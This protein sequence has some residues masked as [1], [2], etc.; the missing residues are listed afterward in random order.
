MVHPQ[1]RPR[2]RAI[3][4]YPGSNGLAIYFPAYHDGMSWR[5]TDTGAIW[6]DHTTWDEFLADFTN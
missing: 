5:Y 4:S 3:A 1:N 6:Y 2:R